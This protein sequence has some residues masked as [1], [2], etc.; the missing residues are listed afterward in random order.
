MK[1]RDIIKRCIPF[2]PFT[3]LIIVSV[4]II[5]VA[6]PNEGVLTY[7]MVLGSACLLFILELLSVIFKFKF[8]ILLNAFIAF[9]I[10]LACDLGN[11]LSFYSRYEFWDVLLHGN[12]GFIFGIIVYFA[13]L[14]F[15]KGR[16][17]WL[18]CLF[19]SLISLGIAS[20]WEIYEFST[21]IIFGR[22]AQVQ[23]ESLEKYNNALYDTMMDIIVTLAGVGVFYVLLLVDKFTGKHLYKSL[24]PAP[25]KAEGELT[26]E[27]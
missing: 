15:N 20:V 22:D 10:F 2:A 8:P 4:I 18:D 14:Q 11:A 16:F 26:E 21:D 3:L 9:H 25:K 5:G 12:S 24:A 17:S 27:K 7:L 6:G 23:W 13:M 19:I 1:F